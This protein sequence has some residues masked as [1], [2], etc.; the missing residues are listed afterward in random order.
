VFLDGFF[1]K[2]QSAPYYEIIWNSDIEVAIV[3][4]DFSWL[5]EFFS[6]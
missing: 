3:L 6:K 5:D 2:N 1:K 4:K